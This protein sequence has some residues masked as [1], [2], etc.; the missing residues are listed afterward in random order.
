M[1]IDIRETIAAIRGAAEV[2]DAGEDFLTVAAAEE[3]MSN[4][5]SARKKEIDELRA[6][7][8]EWAHILEAAQH[9]ARRPDSVPSQR[10]HA[11]LLEELDNKKVSLGKAINEAESSL[12][13]KEAELA[14]LKEEL[15]ELEEE[16]PAAEHELNATAL[17]LQIYKGLGFEPV[18]DR[19]G[20]MKKMLIRA[21]S[22]DIHCL[23]FNDSQKS[24]YES[25]Q[26]AWQLASS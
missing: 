14:R 25:V 20:K 19:T 9:S 8:R 7:E 10:K 17:R 6:K 22:G 26:E 12:A 23:T 18:M 21:Q 13:S 16:D 24:S 15:H 3:L 5:A 1:S 4:T 11:A 2:I